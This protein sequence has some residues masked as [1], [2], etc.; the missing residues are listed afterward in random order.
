[1][2]PLIS[3]GSLIIHLA[4]DSYIVILLIRLLLQ[5]LV[6]NWFN[7]LSQFVIQLTEKPL[8]PIRKIIPG[9]AGFDLSILLLA[10]VLQY[11]E[12]SLLWMLQFGPIPHVIGTLIVTISEIASKFVYI[13]IYAIIINAIASWIPQMQTQPILQIVYLIVNPLLSRIQRHVP[14]IAGIDISPIFALLAL[15]LINMLIVQS[16]FNLGTQIILG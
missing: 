12:I 6:A 4:F 1:M 2:S 7:P 10:F 9:F 15:T 13:Y 3:A 5:K 11:I 8:K 16:F 14:L